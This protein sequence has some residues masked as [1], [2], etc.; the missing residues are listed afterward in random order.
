MAHRNRLKWVGILAVVAVA[1]PAWTTCGAEISPNAGNSG[2]KYTLNKLSVY[3]SAPVQVVKRKNP[4]LPESSND[5]SGEFL[6]YPQ[7]SRLSNGDLLAQI[8]LG[9][10]SWHADIEG[11]IGFSWSCDGGTTWSEL[12]VASKHNGYGSLVLPSGDLM[13][14]P[15]ILAAAPNGLVGPYN[16]IRPGKRDVQF[17]DNAVEVTGFL[18]MPAADPTMDTTWQK[19]DKAF[20]VGG[21]VFDGRPVRTGSGWLTTLYGKYEGELKKKCTLH[22]AASVDGLNWRIRSTIAAADSALGRHHWGNSEAEICRLPDARLMCVYRID[23]ES[24]GQSFSSDEGFTWTQPNQMPPGVGTVEPRLAVT[25]NGVVA[26]CGGRPGYYLWL[27]AD[28]KGTDWQRIDIFAH[29]NALAP[30]EQVRFA[31]PGGYRFD[32]CSA[33]GSVVPVSDSEVLVIY[34]C[35]TLDEFGIYVVRASIEKTSDTP[36]MGS[37]AARPVSAG[38]R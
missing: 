28:G 37:K 25:N 22:A 30:P 38:R 24:Y 19:T 17:V 20:K 4:R 11:P 15:Y 7:V 31:G 33:Y 5:P 2:R 8:R 18:R 16:L 32:G 6:W 1:V 21:F 27:N 13:I 34:D 9:G 35:F 10:D 26:L 14:L 29:H 23:G 3:V 36:V 12:L